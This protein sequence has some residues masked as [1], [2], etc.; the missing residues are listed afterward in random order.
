MIVPSWDQIVA[1]LGL[2][3]W[4]LWVTIAVLIAFF[5]LRDTKLLQYFEEKLVQLG[6]VLAK[7]FRLSAR[8][9]RKKR[10]QI[11]MNQV[12][13]NLEDASEFSH[14]RVSLR[15]A[16]S[17]ARSVREADH[18]V[19]VLPRIETGSQRLLSPLREFLSLTH[20]TNLRIYLS[21]AFASVLDD[22]ACL[23]LLVRSDRGFEARELGRILAT[24][25]DR[26][27]MMPLLLETQRAGFWRSI[28]APELVQLDGSIGRE[29][30]PLHVERDVREFLGFV[31]TVAR[32]PLGEEI[33]LRHAGRWLNALVLIVGKAEK[34]ARGEAVAYISFLTRLLLVARPRSV[35]VTGPAVN[36]AVMKS[37]AHYLEREGYSRAGDLESET[38]VV[39]GPNRIEIKTRTITMRSSGADS[40][41][42]QESV[43]TPKQL[44]AAGE[45][46]SNFAAIL[47]DWNE[48]YA[49][50]R[51]A[52]HPSI[53]LRFRRSTLVGGSE[54]KSG[55]PL[56]CDLIGTDSGRYRVVSAVSIAESD[57]GAVAEFVVN[58]D[59][60]VPTEFASQQSLASLLEADDKAGR[61]IRCFVKYVNEEDGY[62]F[63]VP[64][65]WP[66]ESVF[67]GRSDTVVGWDGLAIGAE[68][69]ADVRQNDRGP[70]LRGFGVVS[71]VTLAELV[72]GDVDS[73]AL[74]RLQPGE[75][76]AV[77]CLVK[78]FNEEQNF[79][80]LVP[81]SNPAESVYF[82]GD[83]VVAWST[84]Q[85]VGEQ[86]VADFRSNTLDDGFHA[87]SV[88]FISARMN[89]EEFAQRFETQ[90]RFP[91]D[92]PLNGLAGF[93]RSFFPAKSLGFITPSSAIGEQVFF[94]LDRCIN[95]PMELR[96]GMPVTFDAIRNDKGELQANAV[97]F[98]RLDTPRYLGDEL[99]SMYE[100]PERAK[101][102][103]A[104][105]AT[106]GEL[107]GPVP[108][109]I[110]H[111]NSERGFGF[112]SPLENPSVDYFFH[113][114]DWLG[115]GESPTK[116]EAVS[117]MGTMSLDG[118]L[119]ARNV[120]V[121]SAAT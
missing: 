116:G 27:A 58:D 62:G 104:A 34:V 96:R 72:A 67:F 11:A 61:A 105:P 56:Y 50:C 42:L 51:L 90:M 33:E 38:L 52:D 89:E 115:P 81:T 86:V 39:A 92:A 64:A 32:R 85:K 63:L 8:G 82:S 70:G 44:P 6:V 40:M 48:E 76:K 69:L 77:F 49:F 84:E 101:P 99:P 80:F 37:V 102:L 12:L 60:I 74:A 110:K 119:Q 28:A 17:G 87:T 53:S 83:A 113:H 24:D 2:D 14:R 121:E 4:P 10:L 25:L 45:R 54:L 71:L 88:F 112:V 30:A 57:A 22:I 9:L 94:H 117:F 103:H 100:L 109:L 47:T 21:A 68:A 26:D 55:A 65:E 98:I 29:V 66:E 106:A 97:A 41:P 108:G 43:Y 78:Y 93:V 3:R 73:I 31:G 23:D 107:V 20:L 46:V 75:Y 95:P 36:S 15:W 91:A 59:F 35:Y 1:L 16:S 120:E 5:L 13:Q 18:V 111:Y 114:K 118:K 7:A 19:L 79:G